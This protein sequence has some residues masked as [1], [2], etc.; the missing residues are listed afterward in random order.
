MFTATPSSAELPN[1]TIFIYNET[2][3]N[4]SYYWDFGDGDTSNV[5][6][7]GSHNYET[8]GQMDIYLI[9]SG[10]HCSDTTHQTITIISPEPIASFTASGDGCVPLEVT[11][12][13]NSQYGD[14]Y[15]WDFGDGNYSNQEN[16]T[17]TYYEAGEFQVKLTVTGPGGQDIFADVFINVYPVAN[18][19][20][21]VTPSVVY[22]PEQPIHCYDL[23]EDAETWFW[24]F[25][26]GET[27][28]E[29]SP[30]HYYTEEGTY[31]ISLTVNTSHNCPDT[32]TI[33]RA[34][35]A[36][37]IGEVSFP[38]A[39]TPSESG[40]SDGSYDPNDFDNDVFH[41]IFSGV[42]EYR[43]SI[44]NR[45]GELLFESNDPDIGWDGYYREKLCKQDVYVWKVEGKYINGLDFV[46]TG[47]LTLLR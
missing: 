8:W 29:Q 18:A 42:S 12:N 24:S 46:K 11:F 36:E 1:A 34:V 9:A 25:G 31:D 15:L 26:D 3:G 21:K 28:N 17:Y 5:E 16:P 33:P 47:D 27:S 20:F 32:Y 41:P 14:S 44:F 23:S 38:N 10:N 40:P 45:W 19:Y 2:Q 35:I 37:S 22:I 6:D 7:P 4:W 39:F 13:N 43:L 30:L